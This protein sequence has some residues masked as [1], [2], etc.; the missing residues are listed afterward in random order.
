[1]GERGIVGVDMADVRSA[2]VHPGNVIR[3][4]VGYGAGERRALDA[5]YKSLK[6]LAVEGY[7]LRRATGIFVL[8]AGGSLKLGEVAD[9]S[10]L[11]RLVTG[12][13]PH[14]YPGAYPDERLGRL[15]RVTLVSLRRVMPNEYGTPRSNPSRD[16]WIAPRKRLLTREYRA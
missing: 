2:L 16:C 15:L 6:S 4:G 11:I 14:V 7:P 3:I 8:V 1:M 5:A 12:K 10:R 9:V 13:H